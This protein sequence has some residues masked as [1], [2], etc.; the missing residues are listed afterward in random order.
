MSQIVVG[1]EMRVKYINS[2]EYKLRERLAQ[3]A[4]EIV[5]RDD[6]KDLGSYRQLSRA[7]NKLLH[8]KELIKIG[9]GVYAKARPSE[10]INE[11]ILRK[12][13]DAV[14]MEALDRLGVDWELGQALQDYNAGRTQQVPAKFIVRLKS[15]LRRKLGSGKRQV[16]F[17]G[18]LNAC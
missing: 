5:L 14:M 9:F 8:N 16:V 12:P 18:G 2:I 15:R 3:Q 13:L 10:Y 4:G 11:A 6:V 7:V 17:E 1:M